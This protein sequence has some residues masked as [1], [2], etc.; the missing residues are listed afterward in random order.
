MRADDLDE[1]YRRTGRAYKK[2]VEL[3]CKIDIVNSL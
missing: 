3:F 1:V 2:R